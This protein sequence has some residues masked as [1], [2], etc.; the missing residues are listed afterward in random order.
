MHEAR[1]L[2]EA[3]QTFEFHGYRFRILRRTRNQ[4]AQ[5]RVTPPQRRPIGAT[6][7]ADAEE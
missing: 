3:G 4:I 5:I 2:P 6:A 7:E 1:L